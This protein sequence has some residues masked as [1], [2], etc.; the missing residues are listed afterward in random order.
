MT[1][2]IA[3]GVLATRTEPALNVL[4]KTVEKLNKDSFSKG[5]LVV[6]VCIGVGITASAPRC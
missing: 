4:A 1:V 5:T 2:Q 6:T 3:L